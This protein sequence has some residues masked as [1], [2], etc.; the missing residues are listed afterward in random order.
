MS[1]AKAQLFIS[2]SVDIVRNYQQA[3]QKK[4]S[5]S[6]ATQIR[7]CVIKLKYK[8]KQANYVYM[9]KFQLFISRGVD[10]VPKSQHTMWRF[11]S[12]HRAN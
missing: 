1:V 4:N 6:K 3:M 2:Q 7:V 8:K 11:P 9:A 12:D 5:G 10:I